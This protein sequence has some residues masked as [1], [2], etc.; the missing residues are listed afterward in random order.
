M[1]KNV[2]GNNHTECQKI[3]LHMSGQILYKIVYKEALC[4]WD[5]KTNEQIQKE[6]WLFLFHI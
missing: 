5:F 3:S 1:C 2:T 6:P 4:Q